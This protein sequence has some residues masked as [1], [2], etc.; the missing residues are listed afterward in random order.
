MKFYLL[1]KMG[2]FMVINGN[3]VNLFE[4]SIIVN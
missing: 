1:I 4:M 3:F 2:V